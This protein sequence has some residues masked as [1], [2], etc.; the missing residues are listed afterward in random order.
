MLHTVA[1]MRFTQSSYSQDETITPL[2]V[3]L[4]LDTFG[5]IGS[6]TQSI[7]QNIIEEITAFAQGGDTATGA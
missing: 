6:G 2:S 4:V 1:F 5:G 7:T 3:R